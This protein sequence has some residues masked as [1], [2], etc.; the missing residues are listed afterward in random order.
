MAVARCSDVFDERGGGG[1]QLRRGSVLGVAGHGSVDDVRQV[2]DVSVDGQVV[3]DA[4]ED[5]GEGGRAEEL[6]EATVDGSEV[7]LER[8]LV[9][10]L[11]GTV[12]VE[13]HVGPSR[14]TVTGVGARDPRSGAHRPSTRAGGRWGVRRCSVGWPRRHERCSVRARAGRRRHRS[15]SRAGDGVESGRRRPRLGERDR[16]AELSSSVVVAKSAS[17]SAWCC[18]AALSSASA[19]SGSTS[20]RAVSAPKAASASSATDRMRFL[21][22][23][24]PCRVSGP[25][26]AVGTNTLSAGPRW[27]ASRTRSSWRITSMA[28]FPALGIPS[29]YR[30]LAS[31]T[32]R[33]ATHAPCR[34]PAGVVEG[35]HRTPAAPPRTRAGPGR[36]VR[37]AVS[38]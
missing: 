25:C 35:R 6:D 14:R 24:G 33:D 29:S 22:R 5:D 30:S 2:G 17:P 12:T 3:V 16:Q 1:V 32:G 31:G 37:P 21:S 34:R 26:R 15:R 9:E 8:L 36:E 7:A 23:V 18:H 4:G 27:V 11:A 20:S 10:F 28:G 38:A 13:P 19:C